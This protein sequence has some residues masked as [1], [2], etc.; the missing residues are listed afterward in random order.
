MIIPG[1]ATFLW[2]RRKGNAE[3]LSC[4]GLG[5]QQAAVK[6]Q[7]IIDHALGRKTLPGTLKGA[8]GIGS[9]QVAVVTEL[10]N[11]IGQTGSI[12]GAEI[13][14]GVTPYFTKARNIIGH[15]RTAG[16][17]GLE[18]RHAIWLCE[19]SREINRHVA[20]RRYKL[21]CVMVRQ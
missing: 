11:G 7:V 19:R 4:S 8:I 13:Q 16:K 18:W 20:V 2:A 21:K 17:C 9:A 10:A 12:I 1:F 6:F 15:D 14:G 5:V 3:N